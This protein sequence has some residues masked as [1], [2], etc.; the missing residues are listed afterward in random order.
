MVRDGYSDA[1]MRTKKGDRISQTAFG[2]GFKCNSVV[3]RA[4]KDI[5]PGE[6]YRWMDAI[7]EFPVHVPKV[8]TINLSLFSSSSS[9]FPLELRI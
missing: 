5:Q 8:A 2:S 6:I 4:L 7:D 1:K 9:F 3:W